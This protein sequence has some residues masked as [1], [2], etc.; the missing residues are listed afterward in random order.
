MEQS[1]PM[2][3]REPLLPEKRHDWQQ[4]DADVGG[5]VYS[6]QGN[7]QHHIEQA[8]N[9]MTACSCLHSINWIAAY[10][11][12]VCLKP[13]S[14]ADQDFH[15]HSPTSISE[16][17]AVNEWSTGLAAYIPNEISPSPLSK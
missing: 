10:W 1:E 3:P 7:C 13:V 16:N 2:L 8:I 9:R 4:V 5:E 17:C 6:S 15:L 14:S 12:A 11:F